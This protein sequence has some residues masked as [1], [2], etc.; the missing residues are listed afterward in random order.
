VKAAPPLPRRPR[1]RSC[2]GDANAS[3]AGLLTIGSADH[4][5]KADRDRRR[6]GFGA[7]ILTVGGPPT[8]LD[9][10]A[11]YDRKYDETGNYTQQWTARHRGP[12]SWPE[13]GSLRVG[14]RGDESV[15]LSTPYRSRL[16]RSHRLRRLGRYP[17]SPRR[18]T[19]GGEGGEAVDPLRD[20]SEMTKWPPG[21]PGCRGQRRARPL[22]HRA[23]PRTAR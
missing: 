17:C 5:D 10:I 1:P 13:V 16:V 23:G 11:G 18:P 4:R 6:T 12:P 19:G 20:G 3:F 9:P 15:R 22:R 2:P 21:R 14:D 7:A 8:G